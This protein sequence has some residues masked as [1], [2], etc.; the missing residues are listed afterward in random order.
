M[1]YMED[2]EVNAPEEKFIVDSDAKALWAVRKIREAE[3]ERDK[4]TAFYKKQ[5]E[6]AIEETRFRVDRLK[7]LLEDYSRTVPMKETKTQFSYAL[8]GV[9]L[10]WKKQKANILHDDEKIIE[11]LKA[12]GKTEFIKVINVEKL[13]WVGLKK[14][15]TEDGEMV[16]GIS[17]QIEPER[18]EVKMEEE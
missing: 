4:L 14:R 16:D 7:A 17:V 2:Y 8:P 15:F 6:K 3:A 9:K 11:A 18:F 1:T 13:D 5:I 12:S 10:V